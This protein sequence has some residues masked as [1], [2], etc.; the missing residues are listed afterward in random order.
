MNIPPH[1]WHEEILKNRD[2]IATLMTLECGKPLA[3]ARNEIE[4]G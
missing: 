3:E 1:R 2:D 4:S